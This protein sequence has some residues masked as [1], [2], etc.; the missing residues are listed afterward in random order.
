MT[1]GTV[2]KWLKKVGDTV[3]V[4]EV[5]TEVA[6]DEIT[7]KS[8]GERK[9]EPSSKCWSPQGSPAP[10]KAVLAL[11]RQPARKSPPLLQ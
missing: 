1:E 4:G 5:I 10:V 9:M 7:W 8:R 6:T 11:I 2:A 3:A